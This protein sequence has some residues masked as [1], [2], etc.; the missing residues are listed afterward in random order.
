MCAYVNVGSSP[1]LIYLAQV[2]AAHAGKTLEI[3]LFDPGDITNT[4]MRIK[5]PT[6][7]GYVDASFTFT[8]TGSSGG[9]P[10]SGG[11][12]TSLPTS[13][14]LTNFYNNEWVTISVALPANYGTGG[15]TPPGETQPGWWKVEYTVGTSGQDVTTWEVT[16]RG[17]PVHL[18][19][20]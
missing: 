11:P 8:A 5:Q 2:D 9:A 7:T 4:T 13:N 10:T 1:T 17:N 19:V 6:A 16:I 3:K 20:P 18:V 15:L 14:S 12:Q